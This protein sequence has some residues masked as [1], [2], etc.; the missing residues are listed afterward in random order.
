MS[1][2]VNDA[3]GTSSE[4]NF[5]ISKIETLFSSYKLTRSTKLPRR[6]NLLIIAFVI[7][8]FV[9]ITLINLAA[10]GYEYHFRQSPNYHNVLP[11]PWYENHFL[12]NTSWLPRIWA[13][14]ASLI[15]STDGTCSVIIFTKMKRWI[16]TTTITLVTGSQHT[17]TQEKIRRST[18]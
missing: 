7:T 4:M 16:P 18:A 3:K 1:H 8:L 6:V 17:P 5:F 2:P 13:C 11:P 9:I 12:A 14:D 15:K 10:V